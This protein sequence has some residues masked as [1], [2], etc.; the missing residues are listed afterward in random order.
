MITL[1]RCAPSVDLKQDFCLIYCITIQYEIS[2][3][4]GCAIIDSSEKIR[5]RLNNSFLLKT[6]CNKVIPF[7]K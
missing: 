7:F 4:E 3:E 2:F 5:R 1:R 6:L